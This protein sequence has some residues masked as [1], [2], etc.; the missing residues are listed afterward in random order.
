MVS[1]TDIWKLIAGIGVFLFA[2]QH[3]ESALKLLAGRSF[4][5]FLRKHTTNRV[6]AMLSGALVTGILQSSSV[7]KFIMLSFLGA[8][9]V[10]MRNALA[11]VLSANFGTTLDSW[12]VATLGF[13]V[14]I[15]SFAYPAIGLGGIA[16]MIFSSRKKVAAFCNFIIGFGLLFVGLAYMKDSM[17]GMVENY[18]MTRLSGYPL[19]VFLLAGIVITMLIQSSSATMIIVLSA[20]AAGGIDLLAA[21]AV[22]TGAELGTTLK[23]MLGGLTGLAAKKRVALGDLI[24]NVVMVTLAFSFLRPLVLLVS[25]VFGIKDPLISLVLFQ[26]LIN[27]GTIL[28]FFPFLDPFTRFLEKRFRDDHQSVALHIAKVSPEVPEAAVKALEKEARHFIQ[29]AIDLNIHTFRIED[30]A[31]PGYVTDPKKKPEP[32]K[33]YAELKLLHGEIMAFYSGMRRQELQGAEAAVAEALAGSV[34][35]AMYSAK[36]MKDIS[37]NVEELSASGNDFKYKWFLHTREKLGEFYHYVVSLLDEHNGEADKKI[38]AGMDEIRNYYDSF[39][40]TIY[41]DGAHGKVNEVELSTLV[42]VNREIYSSCKALL[43]SL[44]DL[45]H[46]APATGPVRLA[47]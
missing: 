19:A 4:K 38:A 23:I 47:S 9:I 43:H 1:T 3:T 40:D 5:L 13:K 37:H 20:L 26:S 7:V 22:V 35:N 17:A 28:L 24:F 41:K 46:E 30:V 45:I 12:I 11:V 14:D 33:Q 10:S 27:F 29:R 44:E 6:K 21:A 25:E 8:G 18:D 32:G 39:L 42:N 16:L 15:E 34:R 31:V 2:M 36:C